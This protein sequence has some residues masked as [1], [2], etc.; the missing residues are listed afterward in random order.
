MS[1]RTRGRRMCLGASLLKSGTSVGA[2][3][4]AACRGRSDAEMLSKLGVVEEEADESQFWLELLAEKNLC[5]PGESTTLW[6]GFGEI[7]AIMVAS[8]RTLR[9]RIESQGNTGR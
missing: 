5:D 2:N 4:R 7:V 9:N 1:C 3:Y 8:R 6:E